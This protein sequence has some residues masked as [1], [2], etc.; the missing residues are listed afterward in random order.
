MVHY[1]HVPAT[2]DVHE[3]IA[4]LRRLSDLFVERRHQL[5]HTVGL[6]EQQWAVLEEISAE[7]FMPSLFARQRAS[8]AAAVSKILRQLLD[9]QL[10]RVRSVPEDG[11]QRC[12]ELSA[13]GQR[14]LLQLAQEREH[15]INRVWK[16]FS[17]PELRAFVGFGNRLTERMERYVHAVE[18]RE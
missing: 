1:L 15:A 16:R 17:A 4:V 11:R 5:A 9:K 10:V 7:H 8:S 2:T 6:T 18:Q 13:S 14:L 12:Y 3:A